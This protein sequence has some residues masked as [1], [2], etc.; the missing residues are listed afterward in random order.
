MDLGGQSGA[1]VQERNHSAW[2]GEEAMRMEWCS[3][4]E[5]GGNS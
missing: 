3:E 5:M 2:A 1:V 4:S